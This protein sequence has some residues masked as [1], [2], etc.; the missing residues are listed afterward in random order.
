VTDSQRLEIVR[1]VHDAYN[2]GDAETMLSLIDPDCEIR[3]PGRTGGT[4]RGH[5]E[6]LEFLEE[7]MESWD[8]YRVE[9]EEYRETDEWVVACMMQSG[10]GRGSGI[11]VQQRVT[12]LLRVRDGKLTELE[13]YADRADA[14]RAAGL[15]P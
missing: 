9:V 12:Q 3:D 1:K 13:I 15:D 7:W 14:F 5:D 2:R 11:E 4:F 8:S 10:R 6:L